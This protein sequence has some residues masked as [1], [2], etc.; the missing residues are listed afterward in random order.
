[1]REFLDLVA[2]RV[3][4]PG[5]GGAAAVTGALA[6]ALIVMAARF[7]TAQLPAAESI[8]GRADE[9]RR[10]LAG[11]ADEDAAAYQA[12]LD[13]YALPRDDPGRRQ[14]IRDALHGAATV[15]LAIAELAAQAGGLAAEVAAQGNPN[16]RGDAVTAAHLAQASARSASALVEINVRLGSLPASLT[17]QASQAAAAAQAA[18]AQ[19]TANEKTGEG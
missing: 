4:A 17:Q 14:R 1:M 5:G 12:V 18:A 9:L 11:L 19:I 7:S 6:A 15:P 2:A 16:L 3:P 13:A 10:Q 8:A